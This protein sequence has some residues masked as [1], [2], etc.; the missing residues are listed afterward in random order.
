MRGGAK[1]RHS[2]RWRWVLAL[3]IVIGLAIALTSRPA[4]AEAAPPGQFPPQQV[5]RGATLAAIGSCASCHTADPARPFAGGQPIRTP[6]G[7]VYSTNITP[8]ADTGIGR[9]S[10]DAF[11]RALRDGISRDGHH[12][13]PAFPYNYYTRL[14][15]SG[16]Q[17]P[18]PVSASGV[19][20]VL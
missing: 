15:A 4:L 16:V 13:Y 7:T 19:M 5:Q 14:N 1:R 20:L 12:L 17:R 18:M 2:R 8:D 9:W 11:R 10:L 6:F 3:C